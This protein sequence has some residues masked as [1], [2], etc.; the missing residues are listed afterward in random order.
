[1]SS[2]DIYERPLSSWLCQGEII[3]NLHQPFIEIVDEVRKA[4]ELIHPFAVVMSQ[5]CDLEWDFKARQSTKPDRAQKF[6]SN[7]LFCEV[8]E[9]ANL[10]AQ[11]KNKSWTRI[12][13]NNDPRFHFLEKCPQTCDLQNL[14]YADL[15]IDFKKFFTVPTEYLYFQLA[16]NAQRRAVLRQPY[17]VHLSSRFYFFQIRIGLPRNHGD[18]MPVELDVIKELNYRL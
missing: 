3:A 15:A 17:K 7:V 8:A 2:S 11:N 18:P 6:L 12:A 13:E 4:R 10:K 1:M 16:S 14:G 9:A 5:D